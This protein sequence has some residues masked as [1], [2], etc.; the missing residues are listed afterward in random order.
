MTAVTGT[1]AG[2]GAGA[3]AGMDVP[4]SPVDGATRSGWTVRRRQLA[5]AVA[6]AA[7]ALVV[8]P[9]AVPVLA[10][11][12][13]LA[14]AAAAARAERRRRRALAADLP[15]VIAL[16]A[17]AVGAGLTV[18]RAVECVA[19]WG[20][21]A[22]AAELAEVSLDVGCGARLGDR[23]E[24]MAAR[25]GDDV[26]PLVTALVASDR[27]GVP[28]APALDLLAF[29]AR[30]TARRQMEEAV[31]RVPVKLVFPL[32]CCI[33]PAFALLTV[34]PLIAGALAALRLPQ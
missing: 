12:G 19:R 4:S 17:L 9:A 6:G 18:G 7:I 20:S 24:A 16:L 15:D 31:R 26:R 27:Y 23:L 10:A 33:L 14:P 5:A 8:L 11:G 22:L 13:W 32:V 25:L 34:A 1:G 29:E 21:G 2:A 3:G 30:A 28:I